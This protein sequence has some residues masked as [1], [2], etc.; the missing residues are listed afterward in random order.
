MIKR[1]LVGSVVLKYVISFNCEYM[2]YCDDEVCLK[3]IKTNTHSVFDL[4][5]LNRLIDT[6]VECIKH[7]ME[8]CVLDS[9][10]IF[11]R[12]VSVEL[13]IARVLKD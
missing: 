10:C 4:T 1:S 3:N 6:N 2:N 9:A 7:M 5:D 11:Q 12:L 13:R 8:E